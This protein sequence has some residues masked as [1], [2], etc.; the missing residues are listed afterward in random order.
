MKFKTNDFTGFKS[1][2]A[3]IVGAPNVGKSTLLNRMLGQKISITSARPQTTRNRIL[4]IV[5]RPNSQMVFIDTPGIHKTRNTL[6]M[7]I[8]EVALSALGEVDL[9]LAMADVTSPDPVAEQLVFG[10]A[11]Q[12]GVPVVLALNKIDMIRKTRMLAAINKWSKMFSFDTIVPISAKHG[13]QV[14]AVLRA[15]EK[16]LPCGPPFFPEDDITDMSERFLVGE[17]I[18]EKVFRLT[19]HEIPYAIA[20]TVESFT[21]KINKAIVIYATIHVERQSQKGIVIGKN[22]RKLKQ[23]GSDARKD[24]QRLLGAKVFLKLFVHLQKNWSKDTKALRKFGY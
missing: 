15:M 13:T 23:I 4:G 9:I 1:G 3:A 16:T 14:E 20:V 5:H 11:A 12:Q 22:G 24:I 19:G 6:N 2:F 8:V 7:R 17:L 21:E 10:K 18:R